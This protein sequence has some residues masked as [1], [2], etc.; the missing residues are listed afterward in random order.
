M[1]SEHTIGS[2]CDKNSVGIKKLSVE[3]QSCKQRTAD[4]DSKQDNV[5][6]RKDG[7]TNQTSINKNK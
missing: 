6:G 5:K 4:G 7:V 1:I 3:S 2:Q